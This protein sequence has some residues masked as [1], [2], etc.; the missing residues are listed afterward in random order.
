[1][2]DVQGSGILNVTGTQGLSIGQDATRAT[3]GTLNLSGGTMSVTGNLTLGGSGGIGTL[4]HSGGLLSVTG[5][6]GIGGT[7]TLIVDGTTGPLTTS[8]GS[9]SRSGTSSTLVVVPQTGSLSTS[10]AVTFAT[11]ATLTNGILGP[12]AVTLA[13]GTNSTGDFLTMVNSSG[14]WRLGTASY[15]GTNFTNATSAS[16]VNVTVSTTATQNTSAYA[17][18][19]GSGTTTTLGT[20]A[21]IT[22]TSGGM[23]F[24][25]GTLTGGTVAFAGATPLFFAG[26]AG[27]GTI[28]STISGTAGFVKFGPGA[29]ALSNDNSTTLSG[30][31]A[32]NS[33]TVK[34]QRAGSL[35]SGPTTV[36]AGAALE[37]KNSAGM[38]V[39]NVLT[40][41]GSGV[42]GAGALRNVL[43]NNSLSSTISL[44]SN[45]Q[46]NTSGVLTLNGALASI[47]TL[48]KTGVGT[49]I[50]NDDNSASLAGPVIVG[51]GTLRLSCNT[52][53]GPGN[54]SANLTVNSGS[55]VQLQGGISTPSVPITLSGTGT[56]G[57]GALENFSGSN[58]LAGRSRWQRTAWSVST[59]LATR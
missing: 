5:T 35:G 18:K 3:S 14:L 58:S 1:V 46:I 9:L 25:G 47:Y 59:T 41:N 22:V 53:L 48:T 27:T 34:I 44:G 20:T 23:L 36:A 42:A 33:G 21:A 28:G 30:T 51:G 10:E 39:S 8:F 37:L 19:F 45:A 12:W 43:G 31:S 11:S 15:T 26:S 56:I 40:I 13:S 32:I 7:T 49:L 4:T 52:A 6:L 55:T 57:N 24:D 2:V 50:L 54:N 16:V 29:L 17:V 38:V